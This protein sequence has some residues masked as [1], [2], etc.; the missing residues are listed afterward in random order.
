M[1]RCEI[2]LYGN[3]VLEAFEFFSTFEQLLSQN[4]ALLLRRANSTQADFQSFNILIVRGDLYWKFGWASFLQFTSNFETCR[5]VLKFSLSRMF[6]TSMQKW[7]LWKEKSSGISEHFLL[8]MEVLNL[9]YQSQFFFFDEVSRQSVFSEK[10]RIRTIYNI[11]FF[12][13]KTA[14]FKQNLKITSQMIMIIMTI[15]H[16]ST[17]F[18]TKSEPT[19]SIWRHMEHIGSLLVQKAR[20]K[21]VIGT[22]LN[23]GFESAPVSL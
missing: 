12:G 2:K 9:F 4:F 23:L 13:W 7:K 5:I 3:C 17:V 10:K 1:E 21:T 14:H 20:E 22:F 19:C 16:S 6:L 8:V 18:W 11:Y 15:K